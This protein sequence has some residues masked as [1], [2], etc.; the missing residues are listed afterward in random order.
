MRGIGHNTT[1]K[2]AHMTRDGMQYGAQAHVEFGTRYMAAQPF[3]RPSAEAERAKFES[4]FRGLE[5]R[6]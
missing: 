5:G 6:L 2:A 4:R 3:L 1:R